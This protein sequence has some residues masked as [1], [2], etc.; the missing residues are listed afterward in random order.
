[1]KRRGIIFARIENLKNFKFP[2]FLKNILI[3]S[4]FDSAAALKTIKKE[5]I[6]EIEQFVSTRLD[7]LKKTEYIDESGKLKSSPFKFLPGHAALISN[8]PD[9]TEDLL[10][11]KNKEKDIPSIEILKSTFAEKIKQFEQKNKI[12][13]P[14]DRTIITLSNNQAKCF[15]KCPYCDKKIR[16]LF[17][18]AGS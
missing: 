17:D 14:T 10:R 9:D 16:L 5:S 7:L 15:L 18:R 13:V 8:L 12:R 2:I 6:A 3:E 4:A 11:A 1:M